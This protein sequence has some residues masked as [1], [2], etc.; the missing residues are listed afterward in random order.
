MEKAE[1]GNFRVYEINRWEQKGQ[2]NNLKVYR[3]STSEVFDLE[4]AWDKDLNHSGLFEINGLSAVNDLKM[5]G[6][7]ISSPVE[8]HLS[9]YPNPTKGTFTISGLPDDCEITIFNAQGKAI[10]NKILILPA[11]VDLTTKPNGIY[12]ISIKTDQQLLFPDF[13]TGTP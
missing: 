5:T 1:P 3:E 10:L 4:V 13:D 8:Q 7:A 12:F 9:I 2:K 6:T 11:E